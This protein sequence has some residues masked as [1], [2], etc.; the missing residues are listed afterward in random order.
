MIGSLYAIDTHTKYSHWISWCFSEIVKQGTFSI[1][2]SIEFQLSN[3][4]FYYFDLEINCNINRNKSMNYG[5]CDDEERKKNAQKI[6]CCRN[7]WRS[8]RRFT[9]KAISIIANW[10]LCEW[11][12][13]RE[14]PKKK[15]SDKIVNKRAVQRIILSNI[16]WMNYFRPFEWSF[17][18]GTIELEK[19]PITLTNWSALLNQK[20]KNLHLH[21]F[22]IP[23]LIIATPI[24]LNAHD[25]CNYSVY[26]I[27]FPFFA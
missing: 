22:G 9:F 8:K 19:K 23:N 7:P 18:L 13:Y 25:F 24:L 20:R 10:S 11:R 16:S 4:P 27:Q 3:R 26:Q 17:F 6:L 5:D 12:H 2:Y 14:K 21:H 15:N 1:Q